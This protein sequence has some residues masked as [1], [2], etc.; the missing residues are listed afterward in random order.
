MAP[1]T[2]MLASA[3]VQERYFDHPRG[4]AGSSATLVT[5]AVVADGRG[6]D[7]SFAPA[8]SAQPAGAGAG[9]AAAAAAGVVGDDVDGLVGAG[10]VRHRAA[11][12]GGPTGSPAATST[13]ARRKS[14]QPV[15]LTVP[16]VRPVAA[17]RRAASSASVG[18][19]GGSLDAGAGARLRQRTLRSGSMAGVVLP[20]GVRLQRLEHRAVKAGFLTKQGHKVKNWKR[21]WFVLRGHMLQYFR[22][23]SDAAPAGVIDILKYD[24]ER[25]ADSKAPLRLRMLSRTSEE[26][27]CI[28]ADSP[29]DFV[30]WV[31][32]IDHTT[33]EFRELHAELAAAATTAT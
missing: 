7:A 23:P 26:E 32:A 12:T 19:S 24:L 20:P 1:V 11:T 18:G 8:P 21:R 3:V 33:Q 28:E 4:R 31:K 2:R 9:A 15:S 14:E 17:L 6:G 10:V 13:A 22:K 30:D 25:G 29:R 5:G 27:Y 16:K